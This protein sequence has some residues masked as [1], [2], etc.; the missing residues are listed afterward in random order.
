MEDDRYFTDGI[1]FD[2]SSIKGFKS[3]NKVT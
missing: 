3:M 1:G 2:G